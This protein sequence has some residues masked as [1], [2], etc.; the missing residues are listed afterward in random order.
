MKHSHI[1]KSLCILCMVLFC[2]QLC[3]GESLEARET[4]EINKS[5]PWN[6]SKEV[7]IDNKFGEITITHWDKK[8]VAMRIVIETEARNKETAQKLL[9]RISVSF[10][11]RSDEISARTNIGND[12]QNQNRNNHVQF[13]IRYYVSLPAEADCDISQKFG[14]IL[15]QGKHTG[16]CEISARFGNIELDEI[17]GDLSVSSSYGNVRLA[18]CG[19]AELELG[20]SGSVN[21]GSA[22]R[23]EIESK[24]SKIDIATVGDLEL[25]SKYDNINIAT[26]DRI[27]VNMKYGNI[28][29]A[30]LRESAELANM[31]YSK[32]NVARVN[33]D[34]RAIHFDAY[35]S[36]A[37]LA[38]PKSASF[39]VE[40][41]GFRY[42]S[43]DVRGF[44]NLD[45]RNRSDDY[46]YGIINNGN[47]GKVTFDGN[48]YSSL[49][50]KTTE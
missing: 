33:E 41:E 39:S 25:E 20:F 40:A 43:C 28:Q 10:S 36:T 21:I 48:N 42:A 1:Y 35:Y 11:E 50:I 12:N 37:E 4:K 5:F 31:A 46:Y 23:L 26:A 3:F 44:S 19:N 30:K 34:F 7:V 16:N 49:I 29:I 32:V 18:K 38:I 17:T 8:E 13:T 6:R 2:C 9:N 27:S 15:M 24:Y 14:N 47:N 22:E 45:V